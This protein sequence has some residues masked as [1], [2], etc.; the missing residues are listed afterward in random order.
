M[1]ALQSRPTQRNRTVTDMRAI[2][3]AMLGLLLT[4]LVSGA[5]ATQTAGE[6]LQQLRDDSGDRRLEAARELGRFGAEVMGP[7][8]EM[9]GG[10]DQRNEGVVLGLE[11]ER[12]VVSDL[13]E[14][15]K[16]G[17]RIARILERGSGV[18][19]HAWIVFPSCG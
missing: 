5:A 10:E 8:A 18:D 1:A 4:T 19:F 2:A 9:L 3:G 7:L 16:I 11:G 6:L 15:A 14:S 12:T 13:L 17:P